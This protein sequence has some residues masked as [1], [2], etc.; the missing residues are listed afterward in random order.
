MSKNEQEIEKKEE[1]EEIVDILDELQYVSVLETIHLFQTK[2]KGIFMWL[3]PYAIPHEDSLKVLDHIK[4]LT[5][6][7]I[8]KR[9]KDLEENE[10]KKI[11]EVDKK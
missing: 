4:N 6:E 11:E 7:T 8:A 2:K 1:N 3:T 9:K 5:I 10:K